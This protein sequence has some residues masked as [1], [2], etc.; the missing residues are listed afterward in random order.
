MHPA[1]FL[2]PFPQKPDLK[3]EDSLNKGYLALPALKRLSLLQ[4]ILNA[5]IGGVLEKCFV[6]R[7]QIHESENENY[8]FMQEIEGFT[9]VFIYNFICKMLYMY[10]FKA[11]R[12]N[13]I[14]NVWIKIQFDFK[15]LCNPLKSSE[16]IGKLNFH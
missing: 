4:I 1:S 7:R 2:W 6:V 16:A 11:R 10:L 5:N 15:Q 9:Y 13:R 3:N 8:Y 14:N 12:P